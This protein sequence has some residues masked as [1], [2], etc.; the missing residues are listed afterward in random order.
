MN[1]EYLDDLEEITCDNCNGVFLVPYYEELPEVGEP[2]CC[3]FC[4]I[5]FNYKMET[6]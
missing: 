3:C 2:S 1:S 5:D 6:V 4:G